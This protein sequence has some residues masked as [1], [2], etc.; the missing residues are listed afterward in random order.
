M[1]GVYMAPVALFF[2]LAG[3]FIIALFSNGGNEL[4]SMLVGHEV[5]PFDLPP[6]NGASEDGLETGRITE[7]E[8]KGGQMTVV[9]FWASWCGPC[10]IE[11]DQLMGL[12]AG[13]LRILGINYKDEA[14]DAR[15]FLDD[16]GDPFEHVAV[17]RDGRVGIDWGITGV[18]E[19]FVVDGTGHVIARIVGP[20]APSDMEDVLAM[21]RNSGSR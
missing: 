9:N 14:L 16:L 20:L 1:R 18:P 4:P 15:K 5:R 10:R 11:H 2:A 7:A 21:A 8:L 3:F 19:T 12:R 6:L 13:G 17:D